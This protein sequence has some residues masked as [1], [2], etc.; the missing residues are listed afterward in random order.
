MESPPKAPQDLRHEKPAKTRKVINRES[1]ARN[2][3]TILIKRTEKRIYDQFRRLE[4]AR[5]QLAELE[6]Q[7]VEV[8]EMER[9]AWTPLSSRHILHGVSLDPELFSHFIA[10]LTARCKAKYNHGPTTVTPKDLYRTAIFVL[11]PDKLRVLKNKFGERIDQ[12]MDHW[13][14]T[15]RAFNAFGDGLKTDTDMK[16]QDELE[17][18]PDVEYSNERRRV[19]LACKTKAQAETDHEMLVTNFR[20]Y[21][22][23]SAWFQRA[24]D[25]HLAEFQDR[26]EKA[27][28]ERNGEVSKLNAIIAKFER[29]GQ[30]ATFQEYKETYLKSKQVTST[31]D[32]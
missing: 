20:N 9:T 27:Q 2:K 14:K 4:V 6:A 3:E 22:K 12:V 29:L 30:C 18:M 1:Y 15:A 19:A 32:Q 11:H 5:K 8:E 7:P 16:P 26:V 24:N 23:T 17:E 13:S 25:R 21:R 28:D 31:T 10:E